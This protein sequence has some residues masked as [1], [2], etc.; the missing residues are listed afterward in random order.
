MHY[1]LI[2]KRCNRKRHREDKF[3]IELR[4]WKK[5]HFMI[6]MIAYNIKIV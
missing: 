2:I 4:F 5:V 3:L 1:F 6:A